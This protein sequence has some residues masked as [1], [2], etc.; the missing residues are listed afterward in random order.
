MRIFIPD[1]WFAPRRDRLT[2]NGP[3]GEKKEGA[4]GPI[5]SDLQNRRPFIIMVIITQIE[6][7]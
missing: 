5:C 6:K 7:P 4:G 3:E 1:L 2:M